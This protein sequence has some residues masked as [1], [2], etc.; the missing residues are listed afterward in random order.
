MMLRDLGK[1]CFEHLARV[2]RR[3][4]RGKNCL[5]QS[6]GRGQFRKIGI[7]DREPEAPEDSLCRTA[8][9]NHG[10]A[11]TLSSLRIQRFVENP[12]RAAGGFRFELTAPARMVIA[13]G[14]EA[15]Q[16]LIFFVIGQQRPE[17]DRRATAVSAQHF[18]LE[19]AERE[20]LELVCGEGLEQ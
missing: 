10:H 8:V 9:V 4:S 15:Q 12:H 13:V 20:F 17:G 11:Q 1:R 7:R 16:R 18:R 19:F 6:P 2:A 14:G 5:A 3:P